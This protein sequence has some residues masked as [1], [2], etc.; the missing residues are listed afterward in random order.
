VCFLILFSHY[1]LLPSFLRWRLFLFIL[2]L[3]QHLFLS[4][5]FQCSL[6]PSFLLPFVLCV[7][8]GGGWCGRGD[9]SLDQHCRA[10][11]SSVI[12]MASV[13]GPSS[14]LLVTLV[15]M[16]TFVTLSHIYGHTYIQSHT[17]KHTCSKW[18]E[19]STQEKWQRPD[20]VAWSEDWCCFYYCITLEVV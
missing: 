19:H 6:L 5:F 4:S 13:D 15:T 9:Y 20:T 8:I 7:W 14:P 16:L 10:V 2:S 11:G 12:K 1:S 18:R 17:H 3:C